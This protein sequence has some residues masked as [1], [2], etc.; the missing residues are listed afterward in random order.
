MSDIIGFL[1]GGLCGVSLVTVLFADYTRIADAKSITVSSTGSDS[2]NKI[3]NDV[4]Q[5]AANNPGSTVYLK[6]DNG[7]FVINGKNKIGSN[8]KLTGDSDAVVKVS[9]KYSLLSEA[10]K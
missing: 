4:H 7:P 9:E 3:I 8:T 5:E 10:E 1:F 6:S 2:D